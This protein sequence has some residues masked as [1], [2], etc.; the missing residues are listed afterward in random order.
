M[1]GSASVEDTDWVL[2]KDTAE[3]CEL[4]R[5]ARTHYL[6]DHKENMRKGS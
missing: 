1:K 5:T 2:E 4:N 3:N 6:T